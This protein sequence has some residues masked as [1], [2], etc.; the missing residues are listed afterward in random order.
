[1][2]LKVEVKQ[3][4]DNPFY[5]LK[6][7][8]QLFNAAEKGQITAP[9]LE[10]AWNE[11]KGNKE[12]RQMF[13]SLL[14]SIGDITA[15]QHNIFR[16]NKTDSGGNANREVFRM[17]M[18]WMKSTNYIQYVKFM[19]TRLFNEFTSFDNLFAMRVKTVKKTKRITEVIN[20]VG[21]DSK[22]LADLSEFITAIIKGS[23]IYDKHLVAKFLGRPR[24]SK[25]QKHKIMLPETR[26]LMLL[27]QNLLV[28]I[29]DKCSFAYE[30]KEKY[31]NFLGY[32]SWRKE[33]LALDEAVLF[34]TGK[35]KEFD[36]QG[37]IAW[38]N[39]IPAGARFRV[40][41]RLL[42]KENQLKPK[43]GEMGNW[44]L[45]WENYKV[46]AQKDQRVI[47]E[48]IRQGEGT[49]DDVIRLEKVKKAAKVTTGAV[50]FTDLFG[51]IVLGNVDEVKIQPFLDKINLPYNTLVFVDDSWSMS[52]SYSVQSKYG[53]TAFD[54][55]T[56]IATI[57]LLKNPDDV[58][59]SLISLFS[60]TAR[61]FTNITALKI[62]KNR[63]I[64]EKAEEVSIPLIQPTMPFLQ[65]LHNIRGFATAHRTGNGTN[66]SAIPDSIHSWTHGDSDLI[67][68]IQAFP[69]WTIISDGNWNNLPS[70]AASIN[71]FMMRCERY[72]GFKPFIVA[73]DVSVTNTNM[74]MFQGIENFLYLPP[75]PSSIEMFLTNFKDMDILDVYTPLQSMFRSNRYQ[76][77]RENTL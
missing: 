35:I 22:Y 30:V 52:A 36:Q 8:L 42:T 26:T 14:F 72:F 5:G 54:F 77:V 23:N 33:F 1:M 62:G 45:A 27:R 44:Y 46:D 56:F 4:N 24:L 18:L 40:R 48:K 20:M 61:M 47:E 19:F 13:F 2:T 9:M 67:E 10:L 16:G 28:R 31:I 51:Q 32:Y 55:A 53:F 3:V 15:R 17:I 60:S 25:R 70:P 63:I 68:Q 65:N 76:L 50:N 6:H 57:C 66:I 21:T 71:D 29:S 37:F 34:S 38:L 7:S 49:T 73:I 11:V 43:W 69:V 41:T 59:R 12:H 75:V 74:D 58:G 39:A 64:N